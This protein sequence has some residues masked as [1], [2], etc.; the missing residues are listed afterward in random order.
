[1]T[2][3]TPLEIID[4]FAKAV[5]ANPNAPLTDEER[6]MIRRGVKFMRRVDAMV[7]FIGWGKWAAA[8][9]IFIV[10][11]WSRVAEAWAGWSGH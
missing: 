11:Q 3:P 4:R 1:M 7:W 9:I 10:T 2:G 6:E 5:E 8:G